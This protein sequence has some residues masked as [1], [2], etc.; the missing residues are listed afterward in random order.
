VA[1]AFL[2][3]RHATTD[4]VGRAIAGR[5]PGVHI[6]DCGEREV[7]RL[8]RHL[9]DVQVAA[10]YTSPLERTRETAAALARDRGLTPHVLDALNEIDFGEWTGR[11]F[12]ELSSQPGWRTWV[13]TRSAAAPPRGET[14]VAAQ[15]RVLD[16]MRKLS[17]EHERSTVALV[18]HGDIIKSVLAHYLG[19]SLDELE[20]FDVAP[21][22]VSVVFLGDDWAQVKL[23]N[24]T[25]RIAHY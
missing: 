9:A 8:A 4:L 12:E 15:R 20:R 5:A 13:D 24:S 2:L 23:V 3:I 25:S 1:A 19:T 18:T 21:A 10:V 22:S 7:E 16:A 17:S 14:I 11:T 6:N